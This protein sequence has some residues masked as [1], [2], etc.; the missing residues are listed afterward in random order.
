MLEIPE[1]VTIAEQLCRTVVGK[2]V[3]HVQAAQSPHGFAWYF[4]DP[5]EYPARLEGRVIDGACSVGGRV[6][7][8]AGDV[9]IAL[10]D[11]VNARYL[12]P[13]KEPPKKH[14]L[15]IRF[16]D[17]SALVCTVQMYGGMMVF[18]DGGMDDN[19]Y[20][21]VARDRPSPLSDAFDRAYFD[22]IAEDAGGKVSAKAL[23]ATE[24]RIPGLGNGCV[25]DILWNARVNPQSKMGALLPD[26]R[27]AIYNSVKCTLR[28][29]ADKGGRDTEKDLYGN[30]GGYMTRLSARTAAYGCPNCGGGI[31]RKAYMGGNVY[32]CEHC[33]PVKK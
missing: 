33:Q 29:M 5:A 1:A 14:Q 2:T 23:L 19:F 17:G 31:T 16:G 3:D 21:T 15:Y 32:F 26:E 12:A 13:G 27:T 24:Q 10:N 28:E 8:A 9:R 22:A 18:P 25:Q 7:M 4:G 6:E 30:P 11:G 20:H